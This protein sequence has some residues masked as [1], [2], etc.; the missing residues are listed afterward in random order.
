MSSRNSRLM[1]NGRPASETSALPCLRMSSMRSLNRPVT[2]AGS[3]GAAMVTTAL[4]SGICAAAA[5]MAAPPRLWP[6]RIAFAGPEPGE[7]EPQYRD[8]LCRQRHRDAF[9]GQHVLAAGEAM[10]EQRIAKRLAL[11]QVQRCRQL[12]AFGARE[13]EAFSW[14]RRPPW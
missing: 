7:V 11:G 9:R 6:I 8:A 2:C 3:E 14:H 13:L 4:A 1:G 5:R 10:R 12:L